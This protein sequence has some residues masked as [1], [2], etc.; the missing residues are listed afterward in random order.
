[1]M[2]NTEHKRNKRKEKEKYSPQ[3]Y[4]ESRTELKEG[5]RER[6]TGWAL[7]IL[8]MDEN[9]DSLQNN[10]SISHIR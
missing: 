1:M 8:P 9:V 2:W 7:E 3:E 6:K 4:T 10:I 5:K